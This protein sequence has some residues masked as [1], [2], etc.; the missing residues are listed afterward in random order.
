MV[1]DPDEIEALTQETVLR[2]IRSLPSYRGDASAA[3]WVYRIAHNTCFD[4]H[5]R[6]AARPQTVPLEP[7]EAAGAE[8][9]A[10]LDH[11]PA[12]LVEDA[13]AECFVEHAVREL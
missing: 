3:T 7:D 1:G 6:W 11:D 9:S 5:R 12:A 10:E 4:A 13:V 2:L 8:A